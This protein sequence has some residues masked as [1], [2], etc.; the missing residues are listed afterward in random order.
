VI[1]LCQL[2]RSATGERDRD[3]ALAELWPLL[4]LA[5]TRYV[6]YH[7]QAYGRVDEEEVRDIGSEKAVAFF[8]ALERQELH[9][10][11]LQPGRIC[12]YLSA[13]AHNGLVDWF[14]KQGRLRAVTREPGPL[15]MSQGARADSA[16]VNVQHE[17]FVS[18]IRTCVDHLA[19]RARVVWFFRAFLDMPSRKIASH[20]DVRM[21]PAAVDMLLSRTRRALRD[22]MKRKG[23]DAE[24]A[25][26]GVFVVLWDML[27]RGSAEETRSEVE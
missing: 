26:P 15:W 19:P 5:L 13:L 23:F 18:A 21:T 12:S 16:D 1:A 3:R 22:C 20:P 2:W 14:R 11:P 10:D 7:G 9:L 8:R 4:N 24:D 25:P 17:Q 6:R 27:R